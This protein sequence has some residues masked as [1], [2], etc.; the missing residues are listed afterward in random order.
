[1]TTLE[2]IEAVYRR[3]HAES[4]GW[5]FIFCGPERT[6]LFGAWVGGPGRKVLDLGCRDG[7]LTRSFLT[8]NTV[9]GVD[10]DRSALA[11]AQKLGIE[12]VW[13]DA[14]E[15][16]PFADGSFDAVVAGELLEHLRFPER[17]AVE[18]GRVL[19]PG[20]VFIG[21]VPNSFRLKNRLR[22]LVGKSPEPRADPTQLHLLA[23]VDV[24]RLLEPFV[25]P[26]IRYVAGRLTRL[27]PR[28]F[29]ND[30]VFRARTPS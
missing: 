26:E 3:H 17:T 24:E 22:F 6:V 14:D 15:P 9:V 10:V 12:T 13:A 23:P 29:A 21:S 28:L 8:G 19:R 5:N 20:G 18:A 4:R 11:E 7:A 1:M 30:I 16:L 2:Q 27:Q 25:D